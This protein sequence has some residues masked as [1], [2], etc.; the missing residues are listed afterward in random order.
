MNWKTTWT[1]ALVAKFELSYN[2]PGCTKPPKISV[3]ITYTWIETW[4]QNLPNKKK[5]TEVRW[6]TIICYISV[7]S[8]DF[9]CYIIESCIE[10][11]L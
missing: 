10:T 8:I 9:L 7:I 2:L 3:R 6:K 1:E 11:E 5:Y 4:T